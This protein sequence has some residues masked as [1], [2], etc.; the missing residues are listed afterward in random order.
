LGFGQEE[1]EAR[2]EKD[3]E[4][5]LAGCKKRVFHSTQPSFRAQ[6]CSVGSFRQGLGPRAELGMAI[7]FGT[8]S[9]CPHSWDYQ[10]KSLDRYLEVFRAGGNQVQ[11]QLPRGK[12]HTKY[13]WS[14]VEDIKRLGVKYVNGVASRSKNRK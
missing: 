1:Q 12:V 2:E 8:S 5:N 10:L 6:P 14:D 4:Q 9:N 7:I 3:S 11:R 13:S